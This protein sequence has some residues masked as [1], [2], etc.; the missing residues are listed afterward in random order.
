M[1]QN[2]FQRKTD[3]KGKEKRNNLNTTRKQANPEMKILYG[4]TGKSFNQAI[5]WEEGRGRIGLF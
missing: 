4:T 2:K 3:D 1:L 5:G